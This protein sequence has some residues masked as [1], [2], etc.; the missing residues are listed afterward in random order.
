MVAEIMELRHLR[1]FVAVAEE[2]NITRA[3]ERLHISQPP[4]SRQIKDL[5]DELGVAL[6]EHGTRSIRL[7]GAGV[8]FLG[9]VRG[10]LK[11]VDCA[12]MRLTSKHAGRSREIHVGYA[13]SLTAKAL[14]LALRKFEARIPEARVHLHDMTTVEMLAGLSGDRLDVALI[15]GNKVKSPKT[16]EFEKLASFPVCIALSRDHPLVAAK[17]I[18]L[19]QLAGERLIAYAKSGYP[20]YH[21]W[22]AGIF[23]AIKKRPQVREEYDSSSS[24]IAAVEAGRGIALV[25]DGFQEI[26][27]GRVVVRPVEP[28]PAPLLLAI[29][30][31]KGASCPMKDTFLLS[32]REAWGA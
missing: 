13:P 26:A 4:L 19:Q 23:A 5:E 17:G 24:I 9:E 27:A 6:F 1:Y 25:Q 2:Q 29:A 16:V 20:E 21:G 28:S 18:Q 22:L 7:T 31:K 11:Q 15:I 32:A 8:E 30:H 10:I 3:A 14:S 12:V